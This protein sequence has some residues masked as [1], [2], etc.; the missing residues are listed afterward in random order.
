MDKIY[1]KNVTLVAVSSVMI[2]E[3]IYALLQSMKGVEYFDVILIS[4]ERPVN[5]L[6]NINFKKCNN[7][8]NISDYNKFILFNLSDYVNSDFVLIVQYDGYVLKP[9]LWDDNF[10]QY[11]Y[12]GAPWKKN[13]YFDS[14]GN[15]IRVGNGGFSLRSKKLLNAFNNLKVDP[16]GD[17]IKYNEDGIICI[18]FRKELERMGCVFAPISVASKFSFEKKLKDSEL[19]TF[20]FHTYKTNFSTK[21]KNLLKVLFSFIGIK[22]RRKIKK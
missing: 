9:K 1:L 3:T 10:L 17:I 6:D 4:H 15:N 7:L 18:H 12:I 5:L 8:K 13:I 21:I 2:E 14:L 19:K 16:L 22:I 20:G 11:D